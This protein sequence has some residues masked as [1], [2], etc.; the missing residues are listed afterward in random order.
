M[1]FIEGQTLAA[2]IAGQR[3]TGGQAVPP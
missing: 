2:L 3:Q 1:Q